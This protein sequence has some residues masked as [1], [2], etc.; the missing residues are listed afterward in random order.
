MGSDVVGGIVQEIMKRR[1]ISDEEV[2]KKMVEEL[3]NEITV[4]IMS[5]LSDEE[6]DEIEKGEMSEEEIVRFIEER[7][8][9]RGE[10]AKR[11]ID[12]YI[13]NNGGRKK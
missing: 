8:E 12:N 3:N 6:M 11:V 2:E 1:G 4:E 5:E 13:K 10:I 7:V 9:N